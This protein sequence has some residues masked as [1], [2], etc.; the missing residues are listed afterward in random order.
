MVHGGNSTIRIWGNTTTSSHIVDDFAIERTAH[1]S[2]Y[3]RVWFIVIN[4]L[5]IFKVQF[6]SEVPSRMSKFPEPVH[7][8]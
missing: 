7:L 2:S 6:K 5:N 3:H 4:A 1:H 8:K